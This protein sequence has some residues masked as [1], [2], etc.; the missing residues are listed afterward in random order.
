MKT[1]W[2]QILSLSLVSVMTLF[3]EPLSAPAGRPKNGTFPFPSLSLSSSFSEN[4]FL[5]PPPEWAAGQNLSDRLSFNSGRVGMNLG[6]YGRPGGLQRSH[7]IRV[8][9]PSTPIDYDDDWVGSVQSLSRF[10]YGNAGDWGVS[11]THGLWAHG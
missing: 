5:L 9:A 7:E 1:V 8:Y 2:R 6:Y 4:L 11:I 3:A 10:R